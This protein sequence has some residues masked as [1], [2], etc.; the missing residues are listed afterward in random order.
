MSNSVSVSWVEGLGCVPVPESGCHT[1]PVKSPFGKV[2][3]RIRERCEK[4]GM[5]NSGCCLYASAIGQVEF[6][7][8]GFDAYLQI[9]AAYWAYEVFEG[10][11]LGTFGFGYQPDDEQSQPAMEREGVMPEF[12][13]WLYIAPGGSTKLLPEGHIRSEE[14]PGKAGCFLD[15]TAHFLPHRLRETGGLEWKTAKPPLPAVVPLGDKDFGSPNFGYQVSEEGCR[16]GGICVRRVFLEVQKR[17][18]SSGVSVMDVIEEF[19][20]KLSPL[21]QAGCK[22][23][24]V[25][26][27]T[28]P[29]DILRLVRHLEEKRTGKK[30]VRG[31]TSLGVTDFSPIFSDPTKH[32]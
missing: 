11:D 1:A 26:S 3:Q 4:I 6:R 29:L 10:G 17:F 8:A 27:M 13:A 2:C 16:F 22:Y 25:E 9:G 7:R 31:S 15:M 21:P 30:H 14:Y 18:A 12:H 5:W 32:G 23:D 24:Y 28:S 19:G 20:G